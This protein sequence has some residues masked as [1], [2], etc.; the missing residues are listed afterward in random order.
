MNGS[1]CVRCARRRQEA[2]AVPGGQDEM[3]ANAKMSHLRYGA[4]C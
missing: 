2:H 1:R 4:I 3:L